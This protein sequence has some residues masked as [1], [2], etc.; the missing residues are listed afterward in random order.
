MALLWGIDLGG[1]KIE[2]AVI[3]DRKSR[4]V[5][6]RMRMPTGADKG[7][8]HIVRQ[9]YQ[10]VETLVAETGV[11][12]GRIGI[13]TPGTLDPATQK[14]KNSNT[15]CLNGKPLQSDLE[16][17]L[18]IPVTLANDANC[19]ALAETRLGVVPEKAPNAETVWGIIMGTGV[20]SGIVVNGRVLNGRHGIAGEWGHNF[21]DESGGPCY[22]GKT[23]CTET[24]LS[25]PAL[26]HYYNH[27]TGTDT[28]LPQII[29]RF[30]D[31][32][33][34][35]AEETVGRLIHFF[36]MAAATVINI[37]DPDVVV[38]GGGLG[39]IDLLYT[40]GVAAVRRHVF[41]D[42]LDTL[43]LKPKL[44]DSAGVFGAALLTA[45]QPPTARD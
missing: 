13:G 27:L 33:D 11:R 37:I 21:L 36:G 25:G 20:G 35:R 45:N 34:S 22:C 12:P 40:D 28:D 17:L 14:L 10:L 2:G 29:E 41:N 7:Y 18:G 32:M 31:G 38:I 39:N 30:Y 16:N 9:V 26:C 6:R 42:K 4:K 23:G 3:E 8:V 15:T 43:F 44:G 5:L 1:T 19:F 24:I